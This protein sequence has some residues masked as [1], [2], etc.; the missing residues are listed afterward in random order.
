MAWVVL[1]LSGILEA[2]WAVAL[3]LSHGFTRLGWTV[4]FLV[5]AALSFA[6]LAWAMRYLPV[7]TAYAVWTGI[8]A[9]IAAVIGMVWLGDGV[10][11]LRIT[12]LVLIVAGIVGLKLAASAA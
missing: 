4:T 10:S 6:G 8:G 3:K 11:A 1:L 9:L 12:S 2:G 5:T 7:G